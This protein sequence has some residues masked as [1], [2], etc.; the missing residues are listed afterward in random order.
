MVNFR[1]H[2]GF[3]SDQLKVRVD[4]DLMLVCIISEL[5]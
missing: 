2:G 4:K 3:I 5:S 1:I